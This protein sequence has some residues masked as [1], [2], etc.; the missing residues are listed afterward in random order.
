MRR[1]LL[2]GCGVI[3]CL[4][5]V[6]GVATFVWGITPREWDGDLD[7][8]VTQ[9]CHP[10]PGGQPSCATL[11]PDHDHPAVTPIMDVNKISTEAWN[12]PAETKIGDVLI[13]HVH[14]R[15]VAIDSSGAWTRVD[16]CR[17]LLA[18][19]TSPGPS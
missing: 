8:K 19:R 9:L 3:C 6:V 1:V 12:L 5:L 13:C 7:F 14:Q 10:Q 4:A 16:E 11:E 2:V 18:V 15:E 17:S